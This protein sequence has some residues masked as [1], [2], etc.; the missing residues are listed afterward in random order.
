MLR[1]E[2]VLGERLGGS[3][4]SW[5]TSGEVWGSEGGGGG[6]GGS[7]RG[8]WEGGSYGGVQGDLGVFG[9]VGGLHLG[10]TRAIL[11]VTPEGFGVTWGILG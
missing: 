3:G 6:F 1:W 4:G 5:G 7:S 11:M 10:D 9:A 2:G 8:R